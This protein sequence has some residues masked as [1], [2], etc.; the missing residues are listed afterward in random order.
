MY[1]NIVSFSCEQPFDWICLFTVFPVAWRH[2][3]SEC[4][5]VSCAIFILY[6]LV[7]SN[8]YFP[9]RTLW[10]RLFI[11]TIHST[12]LPHFSEL[13]ALMDS[14]HRLIRGLTGSN[15]MPHIQGLFWQTSTYSSRADNCLSKIKNIKS[16]SRA[17]ARPR[18]G[19]AGKVKDLEL[20]S[21]LET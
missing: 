20:M 7:C 14:P 19:G 12:A 1:F 18:G 9:L 10:V 4:L 21:L 2:G 17:H 5:R 15:E 3:M 13:P 6:A 16:V 8:I 11:L